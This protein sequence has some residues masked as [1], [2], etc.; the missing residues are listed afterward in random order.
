MQIQSDPETE[1]W[2]SQFIPIHENFDWDTGNELKN[3]KHGIT[4]WQTES[5]FHHKQIVFVGEIIKPIHEEWRGLILGIDNTGKFL[6]LIFTKRENKIRPISCRAM[7]KK[8]VQIYHEKT[9][10]R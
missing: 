10:T 8:E 1:L 9:K 4:S 2:L 6:V 5:I 7:R 3:L